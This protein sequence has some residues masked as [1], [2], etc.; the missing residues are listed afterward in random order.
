MGTSVNQSSPKTINWQAAQAT[1][2]DARVPIERVLR[3]IWRAAT[4]QPEESNLA[5]LLGQPIITRLR[6]IVLEGG[7]AAQI[8][9][10]T[11]REI[12]GSRQ[13]SL[14]VDIARR[15]ALQSASAENRAQAFSERIF[16][17]ASNYLLSRD[18]PGYVGSV[19][20]NQTVADSH[21]F[22]RA[23]LNAAAESVRQ[24][25]PPSSNSPEDWQTHIS[26]VVDV[27]RG[28]R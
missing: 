4:S 15:A 17:E 6:D 26:T 27:L 7:N 1:Y 18:L 3:E 22:K 16:A 5:S 11:T 19:G 25:S 8:A 9:M 2:K 10:A 23:V 21:Q 14:A 28:R 12:A 20:R 24:I 13:A